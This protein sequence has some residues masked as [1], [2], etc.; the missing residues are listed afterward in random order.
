M[1]RSQV[2]S[3]KVHDDSSWF[4]RRNKNNERQR[5][6]KDKRSTSRR[7]D[8]NKCWKK[9]G[10]RATNHSPD[11]YYISVERKWNL[12][13]ADLGIQS[14]NRTNIESGLNWRQPID[15]GIVS[16]P[17]LEGVLGSLESK[18]GLVP[19]VQNKETQ[20]TDSG[21]S[22]T[23]SSTDAWHPIETQKVL[24]NCNLS[25]LWERVS[26]LL[27]VVAAIFRPFLD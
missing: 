25:L 18:N 11:S 27:S 26:F 5:S 17:V 10:L 2:S 12:V 19:N 23:Y 20:C 14:K 1:N 8:V 6:H 3:A 21:W 7:L 13:N 24:L 16:L 9:T 4:L 15:L 22:S